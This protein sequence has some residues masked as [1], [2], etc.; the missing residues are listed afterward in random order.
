MFARDIGHVKSGAFSFRSKMRRAL[1]LIPLVVV[2]AL[3]GCGEGHSGGTQL[4]MVVTSSSFG[5][6]SRAV[7]HLSCQP[8]RGDFP[9]P[10]K[11]CAW[12]EK[13]PKIVTNPKLIICYGITWGNQ[14]DFSGLIDGRP[15]RSDFSVCGWNG[16][17]P[18]VRVGLYGAFVYQALQG[19]GS[20]GHKSPRGSSA[21][22]PR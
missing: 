8:P 13:D 14:V 21:I 1:L 7:F 20:Q 2:V 10:A 3:V 18:L 19:Q 16:S 17:M 9:S 11:S 12:V 15:V 6:V 4:T 5:H 22:A